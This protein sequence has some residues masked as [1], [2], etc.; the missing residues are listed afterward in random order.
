VCG[1]ENEELRRALG[2]QIAR[3]AYSHVVRLVNA[4]SADGPPR[5][6]LLAEILRSSPAI[7]SLGFLSTTGISFH[8]ILEYERSGYVITITMKVL[9]RP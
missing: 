5:D 1:S 3:R 4:G 9:A 8:R 6:S 7:G 2:S